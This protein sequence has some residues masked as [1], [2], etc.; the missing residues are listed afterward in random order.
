M[1]FNKNAGDPNSW[2]VDF[3]KNRP[4]FSDGIYRNGIGRVTWQVTPR[5][6]INL[7]WSEQYQST[8]RQG[9]GSATTTPEAATYSLFQPSHMQQA[10]WSSPLTSR[11]LLEAGWGTYQ[12]RYRNPGPRIDGSFN[13]RM[14]RLTEQN[15]DIPNLASRQ[16][17]G[18]GGG[19]NHHLIGTLANTRASISY[20]TGAHNMKF[21][22]QGGFNNPSQ[23]Y[24]YFNEVIAVRTNGGAPNRLTQTIVNSPSANPKYVRNL[25]PTSFYGQDQWT[26]GQL[27][28]QGGVRYDYLL[29]SYPESKVGGPG[30]T[31]AAAKEILYPSRSTQGI[32][33]HD[34]SAR[35]GA[36]YYLFGNGKTALKFNMG[37]YME[38][39][40]ASNS[41]F[42]LNP[43]IRTTTSTTRVWTDSNRDFIVNCNLSI[44]EKNGECAA[45]N[46][47][48]LGKEVFTR[49]YDTS[50]VTGYGNRPYNWG[51]GL[52]V[53]QE[54]IPR[55][56]VNVGYFRNWWGNWYAVDDRATVAVDYT[57]FTISAPVDSRLPNNGGYPVSGLF[58]LVPTKVGQVD[59]LATHASNFAK[60]VENWQ[61]VDVNVSA[62]LRS[63]LTV[64]G[65]T[66][67]G[68]RLSDACAMKSVVPEYGT[69]ASGAN[70]SIAGTQSAVNPY[71]RQV[72]K[73]LTQVRGLA[74]Y[75][76]P[77]IAVQVSGTW[78]SS[79]GADL[80]ANYVVNSQ[81]ANSG[82]QPLLRNL[83]NG[84]VTVNL[85]EPNTV[86]APRR[87][88]LDLRISKILR[89]GR[90]RTQVGFD[91]YN[92]TNTDYITT[93]NQTFDPTKTTWLTPTAI[94]PARYARFNMQFD[95]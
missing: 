59:E 85:I 15:G 36:A 11:I 78:S 30:Y 46:D 18:V 1:W 87:N 12:A 29:T 19:F 51:L 2:I 70:N 40:V 17:A 79:P 7:N 42:D 37:K 64:Q 4:A 48:S 63:G 28:L 86:F 84:N 50:F 47:K 92:L 23:T 44:P 72:E 52:S 27:T 6:K 31:A 66:S 21:G 61:G 13:P 67:T 73:Y 49:T 5:N 77:R 20:V 95:F 26:T 88:N 93:Y 45:M 83:G 22:Y 62:R 41:D 53:Q 3:D 8:S 9:G 57:P 56:S 65:G 69:G 32:H 94:T 38:A 68:R 81:T 24:T 39:F 80:A 58:D 25:L 76:I 74:T 33:W 75:M 60:L 82:P 14:I 34:I 10:T 16:A 90:T 91:V 71:C 43:L 54:V 89:F 55:V 35:W